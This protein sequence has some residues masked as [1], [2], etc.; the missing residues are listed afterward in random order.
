MRKIPLLI[1]IL[2]AFSA[3]AQEPCG[4]VVFGT[5]VDPTTYPPNFIEE[6]L[7]ISSPC[8]NTPNP[9][10][11]VNAI[12][13]DNIDLIPCAGDTLTG[14][15]V[16]APNHE[17]L[18]V[19]SFP[20]EAVS[21]IGPE[22]IG[23]ILVG[24]EPFFVAIVGIPIGGSNY[25]N[26]VSIGYI[27]VNPTYDDTLNYITCDPDSSGLV[28]TESYI[29]ECG[30]DSLVTR[31]YEYEDVSIDFAGPDLI[32]YGDTMDLTANPSINGAY[33]YQ[34]STGDSTQ[35][36][37]VFAEGIYDVTLTSSAGCTYTATHIVGFHPFNYLTIEAPDA[38]CLGE[39]IDLIEDS[40]YDAHLWTLPNGNTFSGN[41]VSFAAKEWHSGV[42]QLQ[43]TDPNGCILRDSVL[44]LVD[45][46]AELP[47][48]PDMEACNEDTLAVYYEEALY[49]TQ[50]F[51]EWVNGRGHSYELNHLWIIKR[52]WRGTNYIRATTG[53]GC[54]SEKSFEL[55]VNRCKTFCDSVAVY[56]PNTF[57]PNSDGLNDRY[58][59]GGDCDIYRIDKFVI[60]DRWGGKLFERRDFCPDDPVYAWDG[61]AGGKKVEPGV[62]VYLARIIDTVTGKKCM[63]EGGI[64]VR[65]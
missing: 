3:A 42:Y 33:Q 54:V 62:Y 50:T 8:V 51:Y 26:Y 15:W 12:T 36:I 27:P 14:L 58:L 57:S 44:I 53:E 16:E 35:T 39:T 45:L 11:E 59:I 6:V 23:D 43:A 2:F 1:Y 19:Y 41:D 24:D 40:G 56:F 38:V 9:T 52:N 17:P 18:C 29:T 65:W 25:D 30:C 60:F 34:W 28:I 22:F 49:D 48:F 21:V 13:L 64:T 10:F 46:P 63:R 32:C 31:V 47:D 20:E 61:T 4:E 7:D 55:T 37:P 5:D